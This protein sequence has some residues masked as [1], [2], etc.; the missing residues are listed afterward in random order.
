MLHKLQALAPAVTVDRLFQLNPHSL[1]VPA[2]TFVRH[3]H[4]PMAGTACGCDQPT[5]VLP[6]RHHHFDSDAIEVQPHIFPSHHAPIALTSMENPLVL[7]FNI[8]PPADIDP[9]DKFKFVDDLHALEIVNLLSIGISSFNSKFNV[10]TDIPTNNGYIASENLKTQTYL[11][12]ISECTEKK[13]MKLNT[14]KTKIIIFICTTNHQFS[15]RVSVNNVNIE[16]NEETKLLGTH[17]KND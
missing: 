4:F 5:P 11:N 8:L 9:E 1:T 2:L 7:F 14:E 12:D 15:T 3:N 6:G 17:I 16:V 13:E 10:P